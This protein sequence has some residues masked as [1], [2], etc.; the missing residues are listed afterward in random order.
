MAEGLASLVVPFGSQILIGMSVE[1]IFSSI[2]TAK[3]FQI[4]NL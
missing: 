3:V 2:V 4:H 1:L